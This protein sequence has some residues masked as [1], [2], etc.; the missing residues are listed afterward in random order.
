MASAQA[1]QVAAMHC[2]VN[3]NAKSV[4]INKVFL[5]VIS[6]ELTLLSVEQSFRLLR[7]LHTKEPPL[8]AH[9]DLWSLFNH[10]LSECDNSKNTYNSIMSEMKKLGKDQNAKTFLKEELRNCLKKH[11]TSY[12]DIRYF[13]IKRDGTSKPELLITSREKQIL[14]FL[15]SA[16]IN[17]N[18]SEMGKQRLKIFDSSDLEILPET[19]ETPT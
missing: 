15:A 17:I 5:Y 9:H 18:K 11:T 4:D 10:A 14:G 3:L 8:P 7:L 19:E 16:L 13:M 2:Y 12:S 6:I 1:H